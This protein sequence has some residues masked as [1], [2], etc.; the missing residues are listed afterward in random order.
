MNKSLSLEEKFKSAVQNHQKNNLEVAIN[1]YK[2]ILVA[3]PNNSTIHYNLG[4]A[5]NEKQHLNEAISCY[6]KV[7]K[8]DPNYL[9]AHFN[10]G[11]IYKDLGDLEKEISCYEK[12]I[13]I[14]PNHSKAKN[15]LGLAFK[16][17]GEY[18][19]A[20]SF[21]EEAI[22][23]DPNLVEAHNNLG[24]IFSE[25]GETNKAIKSYENAI[26]INPDLEFTNNN[27]GKIYKEIGEQKKSVD[28]F[29]K[30]LINRSKI[31]FDLEKKE[32]NNLNPATTDF[33]LELTNKCNF[34]CEFCPSD[35]QTRHQGYMELSLVEKILNEIS[36]KNLVP[37]VN[38]HLM[39]E[40]TLHPKLNDILNYAK[41]KNVK[42]ALTTNGSTMVKKK[43]P[44]LLDS[45]YGEIVASLMT[46]TQ[47]TYKIRGDVGLSW[48]RYVDNFRLLIREHLKKILRGDKIEYEIIFRVM[49][50]NESEKGTVKVLDS[51]KSIQENYDEWSNF[52]EIV[53][54]ELGLKSFPRQTINPNTIIDILGGNTGEVSFYLQKNIK[55]QFWRAFTFANSRV[56]DEYKLVPQEKTQY[57]PHP[58]TDFGVLWNGDVS[59]CCL[60][61]DAT[62]KVGN[63]KDNSVEDVL[64][65][66]NSKKLRASMYGLEKL[67][68]T[69]VKCQSQAIKK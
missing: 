64:K 26:K 60:D 57:C 42:I 51:S 34:H 4:L 61:Y 31:D 58:F 62:L 5:Y 8:I 56:K 67:H 14:N 46:P 63:V 13:S 49:V 10:L 17:L 15:N 36:E 39:G 54:K 59:L 29:Q 3:D 47:D 25:L 9:S 48:E 44:Q 19:K 53:E 21:Y 55:I 30:S 65:N 43:V 24:T 32:E 68:P 33:F 45:I 66:S 1:L 2:E 6:K 69:C 20:K 16:K 28:F 35:S 41:Q 37:K 27:L 38:L 12:T 50:S 11:L 40:P 23:I 52:T 7:I 22:K 18:S